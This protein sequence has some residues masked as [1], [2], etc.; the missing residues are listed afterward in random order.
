MATE[1]S[2]LE[3]SRAV[4]PRPAGVAALTMNWIRRAKSLFGA[5]PPDDDRNGSGPNRG[6]VAPFDATLLAS[7][8]YLLHAQRIGK[9]GSSR[10]DLKTGK[11]DWTAGT[12]ALYGVDPSVVAPGLEQAMAVTHPE[13]RDLHRHTALEN[14]AGRVGDPI[15]FR[16]LRPDGEIVWVRRVA[17]VLRDAH[18]APHTVII[19][20]QDIS[21]IRQAA[22]DLRRNREHLARAQSVGK[23]GSAEIKL[24]TREV[25]WSEEL[26]RLLGLDPETTTASFDTFMTVIAPE[27]YET[28]HAMREIELA[29]TASQPRVLRINRPDGQR[30]LLLRHAE[31]IRDRQGQPAKLIS[32][33]QDITDRQQAEDALLRNRHQLELAQSLGRIGS[34]EVDLV[35]LTVHWS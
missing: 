11:V 17:D 27:D 32:T 19:T 35:S 8:E 6:D 3:R 33:F 4:G 29:G 2:R 20:I 21:D 26:Y 30:R 15:E 5:P 10:I 18:G 9:L 23:I 28:V 7:H 34:A 22:T 14:R 12:Y 25:F 16:I 13:D 1:A 24:R 31:I